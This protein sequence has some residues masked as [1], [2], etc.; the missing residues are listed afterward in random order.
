[1]VIALSK[2]IRSNGK[3]KEYK[4]RFQQPSLIQL[5]TR[6]IS[7]PGERGPSIRLWRGPKESHLSDQK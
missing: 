1:M 3:S 7:S 4:P 6:R 5:L 2:E